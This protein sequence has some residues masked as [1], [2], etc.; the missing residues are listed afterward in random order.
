MSDPVQLRE[1]IEATRE[2]LGETVEALAAKTDVGARAHEQIEA[3]KETLQDQRGRLIAGAALIVAG[4]VLR[5]RRKRRRQGQW[6]Q[7]LSR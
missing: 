4:L 7:L 5:R 1:E 3:T 6:A 2:E